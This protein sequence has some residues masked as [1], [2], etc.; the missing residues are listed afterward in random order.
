MHDTALGFRRQRVLVC[1][2]ADDAGLATPPWRSLVNEQSFVDDDLCSVAPRHMFAREAHMLELDEL[3][4]DDS[5][6]SALVRALVHVSE[7]E[8]AGSVGQQEFVDRT[9]ADI[10]AAA[11][12][13]LAE[14]GGKD[15]AA[16][17]RAAAAELFGARGF[18][19]L[20][21]APSEYGLDAGD[22]LIDQVLRR[23]QGLA[24]AAAV[25]LREV[26]RRLGAPLRPACDA[27]PH[28]LFCEAA[29]EPF[30][31]DPLRAGA[32]VP[33]ADLDAHRAAHYPPPGPDAPHPL[34]GLAPPAPPDSP[35]T[36]RD[37]C[38]ECR[39]FSP[40]GG[41]CGAA[42]GARALLARVLCSLKLIH[43]RR[44]DYLRALAASD[45]LLLLYPR[46]LPELRD[47]G[48]ILY[49]LGRHQESQRA[50]QDYL[51]RDPAAYDG[52]SV[53]RLV[54]KIKMER[55]LRSRVQ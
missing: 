40:P 38:V 42:L 21:A 7:E 48:L 18:V 24:L 23:G 53:R 17:V 1:S 11:A 33:R 9:I 29:P 15:A 13:S 3:E 34:P 22:V 54:L 45:R 51:V 55:Q 47:R 2:A 39:D 26:C 14:G 5:S 41:Y 4:A 16:A 32:I 52:N 30:F 8:S 44:R 10:A 28:L 35:A 20:S 6:P 36:E 37:R 12:R 19:A 49:Q 50:L 27:V 46:S 25:L 43:V 31:V